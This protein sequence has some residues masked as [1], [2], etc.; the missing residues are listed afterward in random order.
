MSSNS[1]FKDAHK[2]NGETYLKGTAEQISK[3]A[4]KSKLQRI[5]GFQSKMTTKHILHCKSDSKL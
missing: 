2:I 4:D 3:F 1:L 5:S